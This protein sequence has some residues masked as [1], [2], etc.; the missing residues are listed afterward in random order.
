MCSFIRQYDG[1]I[2]LGEVKNTANKNKP[3]GS[4]RQSVAFQDETRKR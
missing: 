2:H 3:R 4:Y 1:L